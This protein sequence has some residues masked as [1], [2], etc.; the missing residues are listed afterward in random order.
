M[1]LATAGGV[2]SIPWSSRGRRFAANVRA[3]A[4]RHPAAAEAVEAAATELAA[5]TLRQMPDGNYQIQDDSGGWLGGLQ[6]H[7]AA[8]AMWQYDPAKGGLLNSISF[9]GVGFGWLLAE[10][11]RTTINTFNGYAPA[12]HVLEPDAA[13]LAMALHLHDWQELLRHPRTRWFVGGDALGA[14]T[15]AMGAQASWS[16]PGH[17]IRCHLRSRAVLPLEE[18]LSELRTKR[19]ASRGHAIAAAAAYYADKDQAY[20]ARRFNDGQPLQILGI[21]SRYT[22]V[23][24]HAIAE[25]QAAAGQVGHEMRVA[26]EPDDSSLENPFAEIIADYRPDL[27]VQI[28]RLRYENPTLPRNVP[29]LCWDQDNLPCMRTDAAT[30]SLDGLT[31]VAGHG[32]L[33]G[34][35]FHGWSRR[36]VIFCHP[37]ACAHRYPAT[38]VSAAALQKYAC[39]ISFI[40]NAAASPEEVA[41]Q[42][43]PRWQPAL[44]ELFTVCREEILRGAAAG[45]TWE[46]GDLQAL[47]RQSSRG[48]SEPHI[49]ELALSLALIADRA[50]R[51]A[52]L[53]WAADY[54]DE[55]GR[56]FRLYG[57]GWEKHP[58]FAKFAAG[59]AA[60]GEELRA[61]YQASTINL[62]LIEGGF[63][64]SRALDG[65][66]AG[67]FFLTR[68]SGNDSRSDALSHA[69]H[70][71]G[72]RAVQLGIRTLRGLRES[73][74][75][76]A[77]A[78]IATLGE[79]LA[80]YNIDE[81]LRALENW[82]ALPQ[83]PVVF[84]QL[85]DVRFAT[86]AEF[87]ALAGRY[88]VDGEARK[89]V[90]T[91]MRS[92]VESEFTHARRWRQFLSH[93][94]AALA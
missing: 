43:A 92:V 59:P 44:G 50:F 29:F 38:P 35:S 58:R 78:A 53:H 91:G 55:T 48:L 45:R 19:D 88:I 41:A 83:A 60:Q 1:T 39:D 11:F 2:S 57:N 94:A 30:A 51:H 25:L 21:T 24:K 16:V 17:V 5:Y 18:S 13:A 52:A 14:F 49:N 86:A 10:V 62:Q 27:I 46:F 82:A 63:L 71:L 12:I 65:L 74:D 56:T 20:W 33:H 9:D 87:R 42:Q 90:A 84:P 36:N 54:A 28:S 73:N 34:W 93:I 79:H 76:A 7:K 72:T 67:G 37:A 47:L 3:L 31:F 69:L 15:S 40:S 75:P 66:A 85:A 26:I 8:T 6:N 77:V 89:R 4:E 68:A 23:L 64:H 80:A 81:P 70:T 22:T 32:A 61:I